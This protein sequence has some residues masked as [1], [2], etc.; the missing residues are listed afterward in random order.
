VISWFTKNKLTSLY[1]KQRSDVKAKQ[2][3]TKNMILNITLQA[4]EVML[5]NIID[6][7]Q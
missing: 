1:K 5:K 3:K 6:I 4:N 7:A 2:K